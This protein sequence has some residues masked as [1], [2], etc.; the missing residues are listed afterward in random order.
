MRYAAILNRDGGTLRTMDLDA[1][2]TRAAAIF[3]GHGHEFSCRIVAGPEIADALE[4]VVKDD[5]VDVFLAGGGDGTISAAAAIA[6]SSGKPL[7]VLPAGTMNMFARALGLPLDLEMALEALAGGAVGQVDIA[8]ANE[9]PFVYQFGVGLHA[10]LV[11]IRE[12]MTYSSRIGKIFAS[13]RA[14]GSTVAR[15]PNFAVEIHCGGSIDKRRASGIAVSNNLLAE[16]HLPHADGL[17]DGVLG[18][19]VAAA[20]NTWALVKL[21]FDVLRGHWRASPMVSEKVSNEVR[22]LF[23]RQRGSAK[24]VIDG[25]LMKLPPEVILKLH[26]KALRVILPKPETAAGPGR[27]AKF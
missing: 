23:P 14:V 13:V 20:M 17:K 11:R 21:A 26:H 10:R 12:T 18:V 15:P 3:A 27:V 2:C 19:Y 5:N 7:A 1:F 6:F 16:G 25:E 9:R 22:L 24:A 8:T 4:A